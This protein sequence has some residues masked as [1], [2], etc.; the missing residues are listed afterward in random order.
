MTP[1]RLTMPLPAAALS[2]NARVHWAR[3][4]R[5]VKHQRQVAWVLAVKAMR[6]AGIRAPFWERAEAE[7]TF[8]WPTRHKRDRDNAAA[9]LK[10]YVD[11]IADAGVLA[12]D[13]G[14][15]HL[16]VRMEYDKANPRVEIIIRALEAA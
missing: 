6:E 3:K 2:P 14:L 11:G 12:D 1:V 7:V 16:P 9:R 8:Y 5:V 10:S 13:A 4:A 15:V